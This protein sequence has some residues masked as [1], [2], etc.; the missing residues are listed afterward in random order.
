MN[1]ILFFCTFFLLDA[2]MIQ[3]QQGNIP[4][5]VN[6]IFILADDLGYG[7]IGC[8]G[9][10]KIKTPNIDDL[11]RNGMKF[12][13]FYS[14]S[15]V[16]APSRASFMTGLHTGHTPIRGNKT[17][18]PEGQMPLPGSSVT[19]AMELKK[20][21]YHTAAFGKWS[22]GFITTSGSP[23]R[24][25]FDT[26]FGYNCQ[27][28]A[29]NYYPDHLWSNDKRVEFPGNPEHNTVY[30]ADTIHQRAMT[31][32]K[33]QETGK[34]FFLYLPYTL[35]HVDLTPPHDS[36]Y[37]HYVKLF[38]EQPLKETDKRNLNKTFVEL[39]P[40][41]ASAAMVARLD[42]YVG[43]IV[44]L[45][46]EKGMAENTVIIFSSDNGPH[47][48]KGGDPD[49]FNGSG[50][51]RGIKRDLYEGGIRVPF[52]VSWKGQI[53]PGT[54]NHQ[55]L[56]IWDLF[57]TFQELA[58]I[59]VTKNIDGISLLPALLSQP[60]PDHNF[61][62]WELHEAGGKQAVLWKNWKAVK[63]NVSSSNP[64]AIELY[65]ISKDP[66]E[67]TNLASRYPE[68]VKEMEK[69]MNEAHQKNNDWIL[70][71]NEK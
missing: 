19:V 35:P 50:N 9:Q 70:F 14:G 11:A 6:I 16:C 7:D 68:I 24:K 66:F 36:I 20:V 34:P 3:A 18:Q 47:R 21:G 51:F 53:K 42:K 67:K 4:G 23:S 30:S 49:F 31:F 65:D 60:Q 17:L 69:L 5:P 54:E 43:E 22:L 15:T 61:L 28:L 10:Q 48:E 59:P 52:I 40:H 62:Y 8:Y 45:V 1:R 2:A 46:N 13:Q 41:A 25:G 57:P 64:G 33:E 27:S 12:T 32:I 58:S 37:Y 26:F 44:A 29:H 38:N 55:P 71:P 39:Y 63:L 56:A